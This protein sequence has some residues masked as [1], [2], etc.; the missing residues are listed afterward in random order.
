MFNSDKVLFCQDIVSK[1][2]NFSVLLDF[3]TVISYLRKHRCWCIFS[4]KV[5]KGQKIAAVNERWYLNNF[6][7]K[8]LVPMIL[9]FPGEKLF[10]NVFVCTFG[11]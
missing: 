2:P 7:K 9:F 1:F 6:K 3:V 11:H 4:D 10:E 5:S 8:Q